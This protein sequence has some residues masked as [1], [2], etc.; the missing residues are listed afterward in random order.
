MLRQERNQRSTAHGARGPPGNLATNFM[1]DPIR[2]PT[3]TLASESCAPME[4][5]KTRRPKS[6]LFPQPLLLFSCLSSYSAPSSFPTSCGLPLQT[7]C[8]SYS[9]F[10]YLE[11][12]NHLFQIK[13]RCTASLLGIALG[14]RG[15]ENI[16]LYG[17]IVSE[18][19][20]G[21][22]CCGGLVVRLK[23]VRGR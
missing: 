20:F 21:L 1:A 15:L 23:W 17:S 14:Q 7:S 3:P 16:R 13:S 22:L 5:R 18:A 2:G 9:L 12:H 19:L 10:H 6:H 4:A 8:F 11:G